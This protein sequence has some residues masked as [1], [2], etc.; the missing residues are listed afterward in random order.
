[1]T[2]SHSREVCRQTEYAVRVMTR[3][4][5][6]DE[7]VGDD[8]RCAWLGANGAQK[9]A[10]KTVQIRG[11]DV[12]HATSVDS[13]RGCH[14]PRCRMAESPLSPR[15]DGVESLSR[16]RAEFFAESVGDGGKRSWH[17]VVVRDAEQVRSLSLVRKVQRR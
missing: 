8:L 14:A 16:S 10:G 11:V 13:S 4:I 3:Q 12:R 9:I 6:V 2:L 1:M 15:S 5:G 17:D 7:G